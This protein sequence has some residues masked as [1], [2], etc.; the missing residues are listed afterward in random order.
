MPV[1]DD[2]YLKRDEVIRLARSR[3]QNAIE[4]GDRMRAVEGARYARLMAYRCRIEDKDELDRL[5]TAAEQ[6]AAGNTDYQQ[7][8]LPS[9]TEQNIEE[10]TIRNAGYYIRR[11][12]DVYTGTA[13]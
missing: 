7:P 13:I 2:F 4:Q 12:V 8:A 3:A 1:N 9:E 11:A 5:A 6:L 10:R